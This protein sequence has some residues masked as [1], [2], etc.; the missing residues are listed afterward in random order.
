M[1]RT[2]RGSLG[3]LSVLLG[4]IKDGSFASAIVVEREMLLRKS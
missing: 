1:N 4:E 3:V 2:Q